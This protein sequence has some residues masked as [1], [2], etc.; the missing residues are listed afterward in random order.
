MA[1]GFGRHVQPPPSGDLPSTRR[2]LILSALALLAVAF[3]AVAIVLPA[4][5]GKDPT[6]LGRLTGLEMMGRIKLELAMDAADHEEADRL[7]RAEDS[8]TLIAAGSDTSPAMRTDETR[9]GIAPHD[10]SEAYLIMRRGAQVSFTW[11]LA[12][13]PLN[14]VVFGDSLN[15]RRESRHRYQ[16][17]KAQESD[18]GELVAAFDGFH[19]WRWYNPSDSVVTLVLR[20]T[21]KY[22]GGRQSSSA[23]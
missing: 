18:K 14:V 12:T 15:G 7:G 9:I 4:E 21:G 19:G 2:L 17:N 22:V 16:V 8:L 10:S 11:D 13:G 6:G 3:V 5:R 20:T 23:Q 1:T